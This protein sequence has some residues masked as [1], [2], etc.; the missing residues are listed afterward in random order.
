M[1]EEIP[2]GGSAFSTHQ[3]PKKGERYEVRGDLP[4][5][6]Y[7]DLSINKGEIL[8]ILATR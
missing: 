4:G 7:G 6:Q 5:A 2:A 1:E 3:Q 8:H